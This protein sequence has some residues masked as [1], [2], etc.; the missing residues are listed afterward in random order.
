MFTSTVF[1]CLRITAATSSPICLSWRCPPL[2]RKITGYATGG[3]GASLGTTADRN[4]AVELLLPF[5]GDAITRLT[6]S[7]VR[8][9][10]GKVWREQ[11]LIQRQEVARQR[12]ADA[13]LNVQRPCPPLSKASELFYPRSVALKLEL[14]SAGHISTITRCG[15]AGREELLLGQPHADEPE[16]QTGGS[17]ANRDPAVAD[18]PVDGGQPQERRVEVSCASPSAVACFVSS[19]SSSRTAA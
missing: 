2:T 11:V 16:H 6:S 15:V 8:I 12:H 9:S 10:V 7:A 1:G 18:A 13:G 19:K 3:R 5:G 14:T 4:V 17:D